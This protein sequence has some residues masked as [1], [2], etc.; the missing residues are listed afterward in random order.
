MWNDISFTTCQRTI[1]YWA[2]MLWKNQNE[3]LDYL[4]LI[5]HTAALGVILNTKVISP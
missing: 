3:L 4:I 5:M 2:I 1:I